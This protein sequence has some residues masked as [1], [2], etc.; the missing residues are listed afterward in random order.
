MTPMIDVVF[1]LI[2]FFLVSS[3]IARQETRL[4]VEL[5]TASSHQAVDLES[6]SLTITI[7]MDAQWQVAGS[8]ADEPTI[9]S[10]MSQTLAEDGENASVRI[11]TDG[12]V[13]YSRVEPLLRMAAKIGIY[14]VS[15][16][17]RDADQN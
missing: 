4:P 6:R 2:I 1:L 5:P 9:R 3:H 7:D 12:I 14:D 8:T 16:A 10:A 17:V 11:R 15:I 13:P